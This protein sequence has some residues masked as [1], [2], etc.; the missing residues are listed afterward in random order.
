MKLIGLIM[1]SIFFTP[2]TFGRFD[3]GFKFAFG[4]FNYFL[5]A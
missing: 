4:L 2:I 5:V 1:F 3:K